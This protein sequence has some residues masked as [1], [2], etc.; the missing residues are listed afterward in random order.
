V[1]ASSDPGNY[2]LSGNTYYSS[3]DTA[4]WFRVDRTDYGLTQW[5]SLSGESGVIVQEVSFADTTRT[6][7]TYHAF[8][9]GQATLDAFITEVRKQSKCNWRLQY[10]APVIN[11]WI[12]AGFGMAASVEPSRTARARRV[13][14]GPGAVRV[15][16]LSGRLLGAADRTSVLRGRAHIVVHSGRPALRVLC[17]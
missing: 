9:G 15:Y 2:T 5:Q 14:T 10:T 16:S 17:E 3:R 6:V 1:S 7:E 8:I 13:A 11:N 4:E 12:R